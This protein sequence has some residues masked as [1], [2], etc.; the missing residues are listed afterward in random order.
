M[1]RKEEQELESRDGLLYIPTIT[2][3]QVIRVRWSGS[4]CCRV[5]S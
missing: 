3:D 2:R 4:P 1:W 5:D